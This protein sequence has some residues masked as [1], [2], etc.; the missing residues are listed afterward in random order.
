MLLYYLRHADPIYN[1]D[2]ITPHGERQAEA[3]AHRLAAHGIDKIFASSAIRAQ[4]TAK[5][6]A[7]LC[8]KEVTILEWALE[9]THW[10]EGTAPNDAG[11]LR[12]A[13]H[14]PKY[15]KLFCSDEVRALGKKWYT[16]EAFANLPLSKGF[17]RIDSAADAWLAELGYEHDREGNCYR[18]V[19]PNDD[20]VAFFAHQG[21]GTAFLSSILDIP[22]P[23]YCTHFDIGLSSMTVIE[24]VCIPDTD[25]VIPKVL[26][27]SNDSHL[28][29]DGLP[30]RF[31]NVE[32]GVFI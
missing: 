9:G 26:T 1:P 27:L 24:F 21:F 31:G 5:P 18:A 16:H 13:M 6:T 4:Q 32:S 8:K 25:T 3:L 23:I 30:T 12:W 7:E 14:L 10:A 29:R 28:W 19:R 11:K 2:C 15:K 20:R 22:Y 17:G